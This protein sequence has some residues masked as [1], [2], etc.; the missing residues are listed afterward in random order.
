MYLPPQ[1]NSK[2]S[3]EAADLMRAYPFASLISVDDTGLPFVSHIPLHLEQ[4]PVIDSG[5]QPWRLLGHVAK[6][7]PHRPESHTAM[8]ALYAAGNE[9][10][11]ALAHWM[12]R[13]GLGQSAKL[14][15]GVA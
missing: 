5:P 15:G 2:D 7:N 9:N 8:K 10:E 4:R 1:F 12:E 6:A 13:L 11:R 3:S 14:K